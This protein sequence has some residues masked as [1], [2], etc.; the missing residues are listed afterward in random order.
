MQVVDSKKCLGR[1]WK[2]QKMSAPNLPLN[3][4][5]FIFQLFMNSFKF[6]FTFLNNLNR[7]MNLHVYLIV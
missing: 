1:H 3:V 5:Y 2:K 6:S 4:G 7:E